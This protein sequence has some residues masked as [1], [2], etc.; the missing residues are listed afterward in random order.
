MLLL[1]TD[2]LPPGERVEAYRAFA[3]AETGAC[4]V[5]HELGA[6]GE[7]HSRLHAWHF[8]PVT[9]FRTQGSG[10]RYWQSPRHVS[11]DPW[12]TVS[13]MTQSAGRAGFACGGRQRRLGSPDLALAGRAA[14][15]WEWN[16]SGTGE[17]LALMMDVEELGLPD[18]MI[19]AAVPLAAHSDVTFLLL[20]QLTAINADADRLAAEPGSGGVGAAVVALVRAFVASAVGGPAVREVA[21]QTRLPR[22]LA[23]VRAH[24]AE[25]GLTPERIA[26]AHNLTPAALHRLCE[27]EGLDLH[28]WR[29]RDATGL[30]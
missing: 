25:P 5:E 22:I 24:A 16:W 9:L 15:A 4:G 26:A 13:V 17:S 29:R 18:A 6:D 1:D 23:Y 3:T 20:T 28:A 14:G 7:F 12:N 27:E 21:E 11:R 10:M 8:G 19:R 30:N 2:D